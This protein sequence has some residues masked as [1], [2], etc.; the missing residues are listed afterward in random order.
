MLVVRLPRLSW[1]C[2]W[3]ACIAALLA[4]ELAHPV[5]AD[6]LDDVRQRGELVWGGDQEGGGP[7][8][9]PD[10]SDPSMVRGFEVELAEELAKELGV[11]ARFQ[12]GQWE[13]LTSLLDRGTIDLVLNGYELTPERARDYRCTRPYYVLGLQLLVHRDSPVHSWDDLRARPGTPRL[14]VGALTKSFAE[15]YLK[16]HYGNDVEIVGYPGTADAMSHTANG[17]LD[18]TLQDDCAALFYGQRFTE[19][20]FV[21]RTVGASYY[22]ALVKKD[23]PELEEA[24]NTAL[25]RIIHDG[26]LKKIYDRWDMSGQA[27]MLALRDVQEV[28]EAPR[29]T[30]WEIIRA[31]TALLLKSAGMTVA[32]SIISMPLAVML[33]MAVAIGRLYGP[34]PVAKVLGAYVEVLR[35]TPLMLQLYAIFFLLPEIGIAV[36][37]LAAA[38]TGLAINYSAYE[39]EIYRAGLQAIPPGQLEAAL[40]LGMSRPRAVWRIILPQAFRIVIPP[41]T[42]D[43]IALFKDTSVCSVVTVVELTKRYSVLA[44]STGAIVEIGAITALLYM[45]M[46]YPLSLFARYSEKRLAGG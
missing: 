21:G 30:S 14:R 36:P 46:S 19:L 10:E 41:V 43:F 45:L 39:A 26:R 5:R 6:G 3:S 38:I 28:P 27:Q 18:A 7:F 20:R 12:Q 16:E 9:F 34:W 32:L 15:T 29:Q 35:G 25:A 8:V 13:N 44:L 1:R 23:E 33:G 22:V 17:V 2:G 4:L 11:K 31:N 40:A 42:N 24:L 37:A